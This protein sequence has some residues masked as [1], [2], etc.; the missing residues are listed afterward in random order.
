MFESYNAT[1]GWTGTYGDQGLVE[2]G[3]YVWQIQF[4][5]TMSDK[6]HTYRGHVTVLK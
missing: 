5:E 1:V 6:K 4:G 3:V 2:D